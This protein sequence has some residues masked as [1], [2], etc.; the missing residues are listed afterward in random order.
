MTQN[1]ESSVQGYAT[2]MKS[3]PT[4]AQ[5]YLLQVLDEICIDYKFQESITIGDRILIADFLIGKLIIEIDEKFSIMPELYSDIL[6]KDKLFKSAGYVVLRLSYE[7]IYSTYQD[8]ALKEL[9]FQ[10]MEISLGN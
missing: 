5:K 9:I 3:N 8:F 7:D 10:F 6:E 4:Q 2:L 1:F